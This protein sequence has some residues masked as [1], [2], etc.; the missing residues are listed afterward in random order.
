[1]VRLASL[2]KNLHELFVERLWRRVGVLVRL[3][4]LVGRISGVSHASLSTWPV[5]PITPS[6]C[7][8]DVLARYATL[9][10]TAAEGRQ[11]ASLRPRL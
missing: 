5:Q 7:A 2:L 11:L 9:P 4:W 10:K 8:L 1:L 3:G 6:Q